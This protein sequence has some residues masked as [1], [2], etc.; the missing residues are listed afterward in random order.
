MVKQG[1][2]YESLLQLGNSLLQDKIIYASGFPALP[3]K[4]NLE[5][6][7]QLPLKEKVKEKWLFK[8]AAT[9]LNLDY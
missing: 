2:G 9:L 8:N 5:E 4:R 3:L 6:L 7:K 1:M